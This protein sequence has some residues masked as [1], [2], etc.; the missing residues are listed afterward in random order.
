MAGFEDEEGGHAPRDL[1]GLGKGKKTD[2][3]L[4]PPGAQPQE[5]LGRNLLRPLPDF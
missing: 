1:Y 2:P 5:H 4:D 3:P